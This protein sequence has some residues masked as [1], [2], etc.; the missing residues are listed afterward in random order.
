MSPILIAELE[1]AI[2]RC[3][4]YLAE[5]RGKP[6][7]Q[8]DPALEDLAVLAGVYG[9]MIYKGQ[10]SITC[11]EQRDELRA[12]IARWLARRSDRAAPHVGAEP[13]TASP[14]TSLPD[15]PTEEQRA[16]DPE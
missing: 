15:L 13:L 11:S 7:L 9:L 5:V 16:H 10:S 3:R 1:M 2:N 12:A 6:G 8:L 14:L 4:D